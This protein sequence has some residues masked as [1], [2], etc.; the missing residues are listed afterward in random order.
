MGSVGQNEEMSC[1]ALSLFGVAQTRP[2]VDARVPVFERGARVMEGLKAGGA[3]KEWTD[4]RVGGL[5][6]GLSI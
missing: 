2:G 1:H 4:R 6:L 3:A 5:V